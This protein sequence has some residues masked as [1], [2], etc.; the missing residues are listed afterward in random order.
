[1]TYKGCLVS[2][3]VLTL[4]VGVVY[5]FFFDQ[6]KRAF[7][8]KNSPIITFV[9]EQVGIG[10]E[11]S[12]VALKIEDADAGLDE[13][14]IRAVQKGVRN[15]VFKQKYGGEKLAAIE[16]VLDR[17]ELGFEEGEMGL[18]V[19]AFDRS[20]W[21]NRAE[22]KKSIQVDLSSPRLEAL[23]G[24]NN[25]RQGGS[26]LVLYKVTDASLKESG[27]EIGG[28]RFPGYSASRIDPLFE[29]KSIHFAIYAVDQISDPR[30]LTPLLYAEDLVGNSSTATFRNRRL[31]RK[32]TS[33]KVSLASNASNQGVSM[34][35]QS[36]KGDLDVRVPE[37]FKE[38]LR[39]LV[40]M[41]IPF[42][43]KKLRRL[44]EENPSGSEIYWTQPFLRNSGSPEWRYGDRVR[45]FVDKS[46]IATT[47]R[48]GFDIAIPL[49]NGVRSVRAAND[50][51]V[52]FIE[53][54]GAY[55]TVLAL[56]HGLGLVS[57]YG[58][59]KSVAAEVGS[60]LQANEVLG[61]VG[62]SPLHRS[63]VLYF[64][65]RL[66]GEPVNPLEWWDVKWF[67]E[68]IFGKVDDVKRSLGL[69]VYRRRDT[70]SR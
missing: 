36:N 56:D 51:K 12:F 67:R 30:G 41:L 16:L 68:H 65:L 4:M 42:S 10:V 44:L 27:V 66:H 58:N 46:E 15:I 48:H 70:K 60:I 39:I 22:V 29:D 52:L 47:L 59:L 5:F 1:M 23:S 54:V 33:K 21:S 17:E 53:Q 8:E 28:K 2:L 37:S 18:E 43:D 34:L 9:D 13:V 25:A 11:E 6:I 49:K 57:I 7:L 3:T 24:Q 26:Q 62:S 61:F 19:R 35:V 55:E 40:N 31:T 50:G 14:V 38:K 63:Y 20:L 69:P 64:E 32:K 45:F